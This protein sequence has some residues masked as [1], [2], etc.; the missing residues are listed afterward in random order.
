MAL[1]LICMRQDG[2]TH[3]IIFGLNFVRQIFIKNFQTFLKVKIEINRDNLT[4]AKLI[5][6]YKTCS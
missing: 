3:L 5:E 6:S 4:L 2:F 1:T